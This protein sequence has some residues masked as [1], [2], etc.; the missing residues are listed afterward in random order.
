[1][2]PAF[3]NSHAEQYFFRSFYFLFFFS[4]FSSFLRYGKGA[5]NLRLPGID[6]PAVD[7]QFAEQ[8]LA[9]LIIENYLKEDFHFTPYNT[10]SYIKQGDRKLEKNAKI[11]FN[12]ARVYDLPDR[13]LLNP[14]DNDVEIVSEEN[15]NE[16]KVEKNKSSRKRF[17]ESSSGHCSSNDQS[18][19]TKKSRSLSSSTSSLSPSLPKTKSRKKLA[20]DSIKRISTRVTEIVTE[21]MEK[22]RRLE[23]Q[24]KQNKSSSDDE[25]EESDNDDIVMITKPEDIIVLDD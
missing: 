11:L 19:A 15:L 12:G 22:E 6:L 21:I 9:Y 18:S 17:S 5:S 10:I 24:Q 20:D 13:K 16:S 7:R 23:K 25:D 8:I 14:I 3:P 4:I 1:M 2:S